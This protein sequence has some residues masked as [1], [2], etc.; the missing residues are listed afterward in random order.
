MEKPSA[1]DIDYNQYGPST[2]D[3]NVFQYKILISEPLVLFFYIDLF[4]G[5]EKQAKN[6][7]KNQYFSNVSTCLP[8]PFWTPDI[9]APA[10]SFGG[11]YL[12]ISRQSVILCH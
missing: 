12:Q 5:F 1:S 4:A 9:A 10:P 6:Q 7:Y 8:F 2:F 11:L 3:F